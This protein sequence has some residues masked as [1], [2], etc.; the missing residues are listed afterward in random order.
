MIKK[1][2][3]K[4]ILASNSPRRKQLLEQ[5]DLNFEVITS[6]IDE[7][8]SLNLE[9]HTFVEYYANLK[10]ENVANRYMNHWV[11]GA[12]TVVAYNKKIF[13]KPKDNDESYVMLKTLSGNTHEVFTGVS[14]H[15]LKRGIINTFHERTEVKFKTLSNEYISYYIDT[16]GA[17]DKAGSY[18]IQDW[19][20]TCVQSINGCFYNVM[21]L[22]LAKFYEEF[23]SSINTQ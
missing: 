1:V 21:G 10:A 19:F 14:I 11:I 13:G 17:L 6:K 4:I 8:L 20:A 16:Y 2:T 9:P 23:L 3:D 5:I 15:H 12:D 22:P 7:D 18:G